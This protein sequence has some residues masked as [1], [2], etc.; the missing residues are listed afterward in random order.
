MEREKLAYNNMNMLEDYNHISVAHLWIVQDSL[1]ELLQLLPSYVSIDA[2]STEK[3]PPTHF[4][5]NNFTVYFQEI[6][7]TYGTPR[8]GEINPGLFAIPI[9]PFLFGVMFGDIGHGGLLLAFAVWMCHSQKGR[10]LLAPVYPIRYLLLLMGIFAFY[11]GWIYNDFFSIPLNVFGTCYS[12]VEGE[13]YAQQQPGC[14]Y[15]L[16]L[17][18]KWYAASNE[19]NYFNSFKM[20]FAVIIGVFQ[21]S[22]GTFVATQPSSSSS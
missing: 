16:G 3:K 7:N 9:F 21:M 10:K 13:E 14:V 15:P 4:P 1:G 11:S 2:V 6:V 18:P 20:K 12:N 17:D 8:Y 22:I 5:L 19:L